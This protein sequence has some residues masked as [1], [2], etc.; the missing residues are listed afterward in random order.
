ME[1]YFANKSN[2]VF[3]RITFIMMAITGLLSFL[4]YEI[5]QKAYLYIGILLHKIETA[6]GCTA[7]NQLISMHP[8]IFGAL[9]T[10]SAFIITF[11]P[12]IIYRLVKLIIQNRKFT[13]HYLKLAKSKHSSKL[14]QIIAN[15]H[16]DKNRIV[17]IRESKPVVFCYGFW[18]PRV[19]ISR[20]LVQILR[21]EEL[22]AVLLHESSH[23]SAQ[24]PRKLFIIKLFYSIFF[25][26]P[27]I[28]TYVNK[29]ITFSELAAD[30]RATNN[31]TERTQLASAILKISQT[32]EQNLLRSELALSFFTSALVER[33]N[34]L[35]D[36]AYM[37]KFRVWSKGFLLGLCSVVFM[38]SLVI[39][40]LTN[41][42]KAFAMHNN[43][44]CA[45]HTA[46]G[47]N[48]ASTCSLDGNQQIC[49]YNGIYSQ[50]LQNCDLNN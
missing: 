49:G 46:S 29:F 42:A 20:G 13:T 15:L 19:C 12:W 11:I 26:L 3:R 44:E 21:R 30:E 33:V 4:I 35:S 34:K 27:G 1:R 22:I 14:K 47:K 39:L 9:I 38:M 50:H 5:Y 36:N 17:E 23:M 6:C 16:L 31:F 8:F 10:L 37:P 18:K 41:S 24:E 40:L 7:M 2:G 45:I 48:L 32:E 25:F 28:K 43:G